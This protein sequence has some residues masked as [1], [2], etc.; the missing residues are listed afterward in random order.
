ML[1]QLQ[2]VSVLQNDATTY[3]K[4]GD[5]LRRIGRE[6]EAL[7]AYQAGLAALTS[8]LEILGPAKAQLAA[9]SPRLIDELVETLGARG[10]LLQRLGHL[11]EASES[12]AEGALL[13]KRFA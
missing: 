8:A 12:Y 4:K 10:G 6:E 7:E 5:A 3:R 1:D 2:R 13:E 9:P 11:K